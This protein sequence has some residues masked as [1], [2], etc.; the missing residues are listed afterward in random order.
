MPI[1]KTL[2]KATKLEKEKFTMKKQILLL[3]SRESSRV[4]L[5]EWI[6]AVVTETTQL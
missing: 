1:V 4:V 6:I 5:S 3:K 2:S